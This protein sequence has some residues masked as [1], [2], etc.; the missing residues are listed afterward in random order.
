MGSVLFL[1]LFPL[2][3]TAGINNDANLYGKNDPGIVS[4]EGNPSKF[5]RNLLKC[6]K[7]H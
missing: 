3:V 6:K 7:C 5:S 1:I 4:V 2:L